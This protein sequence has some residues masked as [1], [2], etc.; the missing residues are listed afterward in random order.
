VPLAHVPDAPIAGS[1]A[2][3]FRRRFEAYKAK[4]I[5]PFFR[6]HVA[7]LDRQI[8]L[9]D[10]LQAINAGPRAVADLERAL[11]DILTCF[12]PGAPGLLSG[13]FLRRIDRI[14]IAATKADHLHHEAHNELTAIVR[15]ITDNAA[16]RAAISNATVEV[17]AL[18]AARATR[19]GTLQH[20]GQTLPVIVGTP[21]K[22]E[23][24]NGSIFD[25]NTETAVFPGDLPENPDSLFE[26][27]GRAAAGANTPDPL[28]RFVRFRPPKLEQVG[29]ELTLSVPHIRLDKAIEFLIGDRLA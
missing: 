3:I 14:L 18:A 11:T 9:V 21:E 2:A 15:R 27:A 28:I 26:P 7:R 5:R 24:I 17:M 29:G 20:K 10:A 6:E 4:V 16:K 23:T 1:Y 25:G 22:G 12:R 13:L 8:V 19:E